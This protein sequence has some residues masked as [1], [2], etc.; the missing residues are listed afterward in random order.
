MITRI[1]LSVT[2]ATAS[3]VAEAKDEALRFDPNNYSIK[4]L[5]MPDG[6]EITYRAYEEIFYVRNI[7]DSTYQTLNFYT[8]EKMKN[9]DGAPILLRTYV[10]G[11]M[12]A[13]AKEPS[14]TDATGRALKEG[15]AVCIPGSRGANSTVK[16]DGKVIH[17]GIAPNGILDLKAAVKYLHFNDDLMPGSAKRI[18][19]DGT[20][21]GGAM[22]ALMGSTGD[23][24]EYSQLLNKMGAA[25]AS[26][27][28]FASI[29]YCPITDLEHADMAY[30]WLYGSTNNTT[31][32]LDEKQKRVSE[33]LSKGFAEYINSLQLLTP[34]GKPLRE[35]NY[36]D[37]I[38]SFL[39]KSAQRALQEGVEI[40]DSIG[41]LLYKEKN[42]LARGRAIDDGRA[43][44]SFGPGGMAPRFEKR[45]DFVSDID[46]DK[47][48]NYLAYKTKLKN[49]PAFDQ[50]GVLDENS[51]PENR[52]FGN[53]K[54][55][56]SN[57]TNYSLHQRT[58]NS[59]ADLS[60]ELVQ[61]VRLMNPMNFIGDKGKS[62]CANYW[63]IRHGASDRDI[64][65]V[66]PI[67]LATKLENS[68]MM[69][70]F[71]LPWNRPHSGDYNLDDLFRWINMVLDSHEE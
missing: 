70:N 56:P 3:I 55:E 6:E 20:S 30:E 17:T 68:G 8:P 29:C 4:T 47:Y 62:K 16:K 7:E 25:D 50:W 48:L 21:A 57:F 67:N 9:S 13:T 27:A 26:D 42:N 46:L 69:V 61:R 11:Y 45:S 65:F 51:S 18:F 41:V 59:S 15:Y 28:V 39:V 58:S 23:N 33:E 34:S 71:A 64:S 63:Y 54:G 31:R 38:K 5:V 14:A 35:D 43:A 44:P 53:E 12:A 37:Y 36:R 1:V 52:V 66:M 24:S 2:L 10:G 60:K 22:S 19:T 32:A 49:P 40:P